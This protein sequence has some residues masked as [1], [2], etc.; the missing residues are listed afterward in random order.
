MSGLTAVGADE[1][2]AL[3][4]FAGIPAEDLV[5]L[6]A[7][8]EPLHAAANVCCKLS[9]LIIQADW[10]SWTVA[11]LRPYVA[12]AAEVF[13]YRRL[14]WGSG[15]PIC[16]MASSFRQTIDAVLDNLPDATDSD[17]ALVFRDN[18]IALY[19]LDVS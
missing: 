7:N 15:W 17:R 10:S 13:G 3:D 4:V 18:A 1:L 16:L 5:A 19:G 6:A 11:D 14:M 12:H 8:L 2:A 9:E